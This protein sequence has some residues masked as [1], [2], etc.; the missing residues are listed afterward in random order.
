MTNNTNAQEEESAAGLLWIESSTAMP[1]AAP[2]RYGGE[3]WSHQLNKVTAFAIREG[4]KLRPVGDVFVISIS[5]DDP[6]AHRLVSLAEFA[7]QHPT[8]TLFVPGSVFADLSDT[9]RDVY[10]ELLDL[11][12]TQL[13]FCTE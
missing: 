13:I 7:I 2:E 3:R 11:H 4:V 1:M 6:R 10:I 5:G 8:G 9:E 12:G